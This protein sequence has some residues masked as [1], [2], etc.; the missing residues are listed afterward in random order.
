MR[1][2]SYF[3]ALHEQIDEGGAAA[4]FYD[5]RM[6]ELGDWRPRDIPEAL[7]TNPA[8]QKQQTHTLPPLERWYLTLL[9]DGRLPGGLADDPTQPS[10]EA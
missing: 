5:H 10:P 1:R 9:H 7:L 8:L 2:P 4:M 3:R 6:M